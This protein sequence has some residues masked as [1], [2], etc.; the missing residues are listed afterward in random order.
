MLFHYLIPYQILYIFILFR[1]IRSLRNLICFKRR[2]IT[3]DITEKTIS[4]YTL[5]NWKTFSQRKE[6]DPNIGHLY[7]FVKEGKNLRGESFLLKHK[8]FG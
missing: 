1:E 3:L 6:S 2:I 4:N 7:L 5:R 8:D